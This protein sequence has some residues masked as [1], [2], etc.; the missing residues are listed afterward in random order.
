[1][2]TPRLLAVDLDGTLLD[3]HGVPHAE[4]LAALKQAV[5]RG[6]TVTIATGRLAS[7]T[8]HIAEA[9]GIDGPLGCADG[10]HLVDAK[11]GRTLVHHGICGREA[12]R[13]RD[14]L[15]E[16]GV[17]TFVFSRDAIVHDEAGSPYADYV[18]A[19]SKALVPTASVA[20]HEAWAREEGVTAVVGVAPEG[21][22]LSATDRILSGLDGAVQVLRFPVAGTAK[23]WG[24]I[25]R[26]AGPSKGTAIAA[27]AEHHGATVRDVVVVGD[28][29]NDVPMFEVAGRSFCMG[30]AP[31]ELQR[32]ATDRLS[33]TRDS[34]G[35]V[36]ETLR[37]AWGINTGT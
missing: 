17:A 13:V 20:E 29:W 33:A 4:D 10:S 34:G 36:A 9:I 30:H 11:S 31:E 18:S 35:G 5:R 24:F 8:R 23:L 2:G 15:V 21:P 16:H 25:A 27:L 3:R 14:E 22:L 26:R 37:I 1:M 7:G 19:W 28:W 6:V 32:R 12:E